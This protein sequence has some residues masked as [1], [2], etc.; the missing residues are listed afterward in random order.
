MEGWLFIL[1][2]AAAGGFVNGL[3]GFGTALFA[4]P[5]W[6]AVLPPT[7]AVAMVLVASV[8]TGLM[9]LWEVRAAIAAQP[10]RLARFALPALAGLPLGSAALLR[11]DAD[12]LRLVV[13]TLLLLYGVWFAARRRLPAW[14]RPAP[15]ADMAVGFAGGVLGGLAGL[16]G[17]LPAMWCGLRPWPRAETRAVLQPYNVAVLSLSAGLLAWQGAYDGAVLWR[18]AVALP[19]AF[20]A[21]RIG[22]A[23]F[24]RM[25][26]AAFRWLL[27][28][29]M[30]VSGL[31]V[32]ARAFAG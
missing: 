1:A 17:A 6:L 22:L 3:A 21:A 4:L 16:S 31:S 13:G 20:G 18:L 12:G 2:G 32:L 10:V 19:V 30:A 27:V 23:L 28:G 11:V 9:G 24:R 29:L 26:D 5:F 25:G 7:Q 8:A 14:E 15:L